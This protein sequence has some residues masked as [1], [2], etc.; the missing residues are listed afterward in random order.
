[1]IGICIS[2]KWV[3]GNCDDWSGQSLWNKNTRW[4]KRVP[5][6]SILDPCCSFSSSM[7]CQ[8]LLNIAQSTCMQITSLYMYASQT[9][10]PGAVGSA[11]EG[12]LER[13]S[14]WIAENG[15]TMNKK[16]LACLAAIRKDLDLSFQYVL[17][18]QS[19]IGTTH[20]LPLWTFNF[21]NMNFHFL[22][23]L[24]LLAHCHQL[25]LASIRTPS[26]LPHPK[27]AVLTTST[28]PP[29]LLSCC[30]QNGGHYTEAT[31]NTATHSNTTWIVAL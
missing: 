24:T 29:W 5:Q 1:M 11:L 14:S 22:S 28:A 21:C 17:C 19:H 13:V 10:N 15:L 12:D 27:D 9:K 31:A 7:T 23:L 4:S 16:S 25:C 30:I 2:Q 26:F 8:R 6:E 3:T 20:C 18:P